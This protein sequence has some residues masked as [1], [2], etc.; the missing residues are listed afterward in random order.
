MLSLLVVAI[1]KQSKLKKQY[2]SFMSGANGESIES[3]I[4]GRFDEIKHIKSDISS[5]KIRLEKID[6]TLLATF[7]KI[8]VVKYDAFKE[9]GGKLSFALA[10]LNQ[11][12][13]GII[14]NSM[15]SSREGCYTYIKEV[16]K[17]ESFVVLSDEEKKALNDAI[18]SR[19]YMQ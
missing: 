8:G 1:I 17:G 12:N 6:T 7:Q 2:R 16:I 10:L 4:L 19:N 15:H 3:E 11:E 18:N 5:M 14:I 9:M 13:D